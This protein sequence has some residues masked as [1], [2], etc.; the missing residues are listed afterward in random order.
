MLLIFLSSAAFSLLSASFGSLRFFSFDTPPPR[1]WR[2]PTGASI[3]GLFESF[4]TLDE[5]LCAKA[6]G[7]PIRTSS[8]IDRIVVRILVLPFETLFILSHP[9]R[10]VDGGA[11]PASLCG[12]VLHLS[13][14]GHRAEQ[15][16]SRRHQHRK[17]AEHDRVFDVA[18]ALVF[19]R[20]RPRPARVCHR[21]ITGFG[22]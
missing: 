2:W 11:V 1:G 6:A 13:K 19:R 22:G 21:S 16:D 17:E 10:N 18:A 12:T 4:A 14:I 9:L 15:P 7:S 3:A 8:A 5:P 20:L